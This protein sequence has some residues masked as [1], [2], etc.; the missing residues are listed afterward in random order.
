MATVARKKIWLHR[1]AV[2]FGGDL[3]HPTQLVKNEEEVVEDFYAAEQKEKNEE[4][5][6]PDIVVPGW[7]VPSCGVYKIKW[8]AAKTRKLMSVG[9][10]VRDCEGKVLAT[11]CSSKIYIT[12]P[13]VA[14]AFV[15]WK[16]MFFG[17]DLMSF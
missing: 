12:N 16:A 3:L 11:L 4:V 6:M 5:G 15:A 9:V 13:I 8:D 17:R 10:I 7:K 14:G 1:N 2:V